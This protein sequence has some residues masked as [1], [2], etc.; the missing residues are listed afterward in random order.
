MPVARACPGPSGWCPVPLVCHCTPQLGAVSKFSEGAFN[1]TDVTDADVE[2]Y[3][4][5]HGPLWDDTH[6]QLPSRCGVIDCCSPD[7][8]LQLVLCSFNSSPIE[9][10]SFPFGGKDSVGY[11]V[12]GLTEVQVDGISGSLLL[13]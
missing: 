7:S 2:E 3:Q 9:S 12:K 6:H 1:P 11:C 5:Q 10:V 4:P 13:Y 8:I